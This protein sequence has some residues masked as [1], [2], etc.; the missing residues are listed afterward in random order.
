MAETL[1]DLSMRDMPWLG[2]AA[3]PFESYEKGSNLRANQQRLGMEKERL[4]MAKEAHGRDLERLDLANELA[5]RSMEPRVNLL[6]AQARGAGLVADL[7]ESQLYVAQ[8]TEETKIAEA[9]AAAASAASNAE[10]AATTAKKNLDIEKRRLEDNAQFH[11]AQDELYELGQSFE[12]GAITAA[13]LSEQVNMLSAGL[14]THLQSSLKNTTDEM[15]PVIMAKEARLERLKQAKTLAPAQTSHAMG[16]KPE[17]QPK[18]ISDAAHSN[19]LIKKATSLGVDQRLINQLKAGE[20]SGEGKMPTMPGAGAS[21][22]AGQGAAS[23]WTFNTWN[24]DMLTVEG[25][26]LLS[27]AIEAKMEAFGQVS[28]VTIG[29]KGDITS[30]F[31]PQAERDAQAKEATAR[32]KIATDAQVTYNENEQKDADRY[33]KFYSSIIAKV[34]ETNA[35]GLVT[36]AQ[37]LAG[38][39]LASQMAGEQSAAAKLKNVL[40]DSDL[41]GLKPGDQYR[42]VNVNGKV[43]VRRVPNRTPGATPTTPTAP[44]ATTPTA[45]TPTAVNAQLGDLKRENPKIQEW[46]QA[47]MQKQLQ[48]AGVE[49][50]G[51]SGGQ[52]LDAFSS[53]SSRFVEM[54]HSKVDKLLGGITQKG[55][56]GPGRGLFPD[57]FIP[58]MNNLMEKIGTELEYHDEKGTPISAIGKTIKVTGHSGNE[59]YFSKDVEIKWSAG[60]IEKLRK[61]I[62]NIGTYKRNAEWAKRMKANQ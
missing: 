61:H 23:Q 5:T 24:D 35:D 58:D 42:E 33:Q 12:I 4:G 49:T 36:P 57:K 44:T 59:K 56:T 32:F 46:H 17:D 54:T 34:V 15:W 43:M 16:L 47:E 13:E 51:L 7:T 26:N 37:V 38:L 20:F 21:K 6:S 2:Q 22:Y 60:L 31:N 9:Q 41:A 14:P 8:Q 1:G 53:T 55:G 10:D 11:T 50:T 3:S 48:H 39:N 29:P 62:R 18:Y 30:E 45:T 40:S 27:R 52:M 28:K 19:A 25:R